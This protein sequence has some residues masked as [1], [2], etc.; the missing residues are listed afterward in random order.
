VTV[1]PTLNGGLFSFNGVHPGFVGHAILA[2]EMHKTL[3]GAASA[4]SSKTVG[5][6][7]VGDFRGVPNDLINKYYFADPAIDYIFHNQMPPP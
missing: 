4:R 2:E 7:P 6:V 1:F 5:G 3:W